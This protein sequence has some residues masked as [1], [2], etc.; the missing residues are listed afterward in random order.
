MAWTPATDPACQTLSNS[1]ADGKAAAHLCRNLISLDPPCDEQEGGGSD[2][3]LPP[4]VGDKPLGTHN[5]DSPARPAFLNIRGEVSPPWQKMPTAARD[6]I[7]APLG[8]V[9]PHALLPL[10]YISTT[11]KGPFLKE[12]AKPG[13]TRA[14]K[15]SIIFPKEAE[16]QKLKTRFNT[17][18]ICLGL[19]LRGITCNSANPTHLLSSWSMGSPSSCTFSQDTR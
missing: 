19:T 1:S 7:A 9:T 2:Q 12:F 16:T 3:H 8:T 18:F 11:R 13:H 6:A 15:W 5:P 4:K 14:E 10:F 17:G